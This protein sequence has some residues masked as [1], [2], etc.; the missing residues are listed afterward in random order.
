[1]TETYASN[2]DTPLAA[3]AHWFNI[4]QAE[5][6]SAA[7]EAMFEAWL[8]REPENYR[9]YKQ[10][11]RQ[12]AIM[13][14][15]AEDPRV[16]ETRKHDR[17]NFRAPSRW[18]HLAA[19][20]AILIFMVIS[21]WA[22]HNSGFFESTIG[23]SDHK[24]QIVRSEVGQRVAMTLAEGSVV[25]LDTD[26]EVHI[27]DMEKTRTLQLVKGRAFFDVA[28]DPSRP[29]IVQAGSK[30]V[31]AIGTSFSVRMNED[32]VT[33]VLLEGKVHVEQKKSLTHAPRQLELTVGHELVVGDE[34]Q[35]KIRKVDAPR[36]TSWMTGRLTFLD[37]PLVEA[38]KEMNSYSKRKLV[39]ENDIV[40][41]Q[42]IVGVFETGDVEAFVKAIELNGAAKIVSQSDEK[43]ILAATR[44]IE[45]FE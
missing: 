23:F 10:L 9:A 13:G 8:A 25:T 26:S 28:K 11:E 44:N 6:V 2:D 16:L 5:E 38:V 12:W 4:H 24:T 42:R 45:K 39:F 33:I 43:I 41:S 15:V 18:R 20:A 17:E 19:I 31:E 22:I 35:W 7:D 27:L 40:P 29:F 34:P 37:K 1:M 36:E 21:G 14:S 32:E 30:T 3:A